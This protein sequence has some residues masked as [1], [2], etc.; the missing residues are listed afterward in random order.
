ME[1]K[2]Y[3]RPEVEVTY[4]E[5]E[6]VITTSNGGITLLLHLHL[7]PASTSGQRQAEGT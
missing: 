2:T 4:F 5:N 6:D 7:V 1:K 3:E